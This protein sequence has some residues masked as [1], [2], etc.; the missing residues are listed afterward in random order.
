[1]EDFGYQLIVYIVTG[2]FGLAYMSY[3]KKIQEWRFIIVG[4]SLLLFPYF[5]PG[6]GW[7][8]GFGTFFIGL[9]FF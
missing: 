8:I 6:I 7:Q 5:V 4:L 3:G 1:M 9:P 2:A